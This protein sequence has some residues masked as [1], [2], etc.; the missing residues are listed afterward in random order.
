LQDVGAWIIMPKKV[1]VEVSEDGINYKEVYSGENFLPI[2][3]KT[4]QVKNIIAS[5]SPISARYV[6]LKAEQYGKLPAW[7][8]GAGG[9]SHIF[10]DEINVN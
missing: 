7:H 2:E 1:T 9:D 10:I 6:K 8:E 4:V 3:D 5:F